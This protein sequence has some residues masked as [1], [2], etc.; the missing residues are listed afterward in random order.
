MGIV[1]HDAD[2][3]HE[4]SSGCQGNSGGT[5]IQPLEIYSSR[6]NTDTKVCC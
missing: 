5:L 4:N 1:A 3:T 6:K 2:L